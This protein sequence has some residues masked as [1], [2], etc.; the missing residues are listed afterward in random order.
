MQTN[1]RN[2]PAAYPLLHLD[3][4]N[5]A[6][7]KARTGTSYP[8]KI[9]PILPL[10]VPASAD[11][12]SSVLCHVERGGIYFLCPVSADGKVIIQCVIWK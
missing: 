6:Q 4:F 2:A 7:E 12:S 5:R 10:N 8:T 3:A 11:R 1:F 9:D